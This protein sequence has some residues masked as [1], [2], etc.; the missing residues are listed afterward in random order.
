[1]VRSRPF[2]WKPLKEPRSLKRKHEDNHKNQE[3]QPLLKKLKGE[4]SEKMETEPEKTLE[5]EPTKTF[6]CEPLIK[7]ARLISTP[8]RTVLQQPSQTVSSFWQV[9]HIFHQFSFKYCEFCKRNGEH[10]MIYQHHTLKDAKGRTLCPV[11]RQMECPLCHADGDNAHEMQGCP[12]RCSKWQVSG[13]NQL[14]PTVS[15]IGRNIDAMRI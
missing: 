1:M 7:A 8:R 5:S 14:R 13:A 3:N 15:F 4:P 12:K 6:K 10:P 2:Y 9:C 11:L